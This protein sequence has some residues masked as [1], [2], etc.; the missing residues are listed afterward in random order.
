MRA[1]CLAKPSF[2]RAG[3][4]EAAA[5]AAFSGSNNC[6][7]FLGARRHEETRNYYYNGTDA[8]KEKMSHRARR[9]NDG[10]GGS[11]VRM[12]SLGLRLTTSTCCFLLRAGGRYEN[13]LGGEPSSKVVGII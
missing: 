9:G 8:S 2:G 13:P 7:N 11:R 6:G 10:G 12:A 4:A 5:A 1:G 3:R